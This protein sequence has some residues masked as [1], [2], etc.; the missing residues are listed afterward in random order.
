MGGVAMMTTASLL[1]FFAKPR[2]SSRLSRDVRM[3]KATNDDIL[4][5]IELRCGSS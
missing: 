1:A 2:F 3:G 5:D 4:R